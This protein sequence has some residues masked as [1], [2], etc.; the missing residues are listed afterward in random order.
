MPV[1]TWEP[2]P[3]Q[4]DRE[5]QPDRAPAAEPRSSDSPM[6]AADVNYDGR[7]ADD[8]S[9]DGNEDINTQGSER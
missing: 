1:K 4:Q 3:G 2:P 6:R 8:V 7:S 9:A 5:R